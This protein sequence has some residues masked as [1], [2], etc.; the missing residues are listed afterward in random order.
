MNIDKLDRPQLEEI[1]LNPPD[2]EPEALRCSDAFATGLLPPAAGARSTKVRHVLAAAHELLVR[3][4][5]QAMAGRC[6]LDSPTT[7][8]D[9]VKVLLAGAERESFVVIFLDAQ[10]R[11]LAAEEMF[12]GTLAQTS[13]YPREIVRRALHHNAAAILCAHPH[14]SGLAE[15]SRADEFLTT[16]LKV[17]LNLVDVRLVDHLVVAGST[18]VSFAERG[19]L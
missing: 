13:V 10:H 16:S 15:P 7:A 4:A 8:K 5:T 18:C 2:V 14:P 12:A 9:F 11:V 6:L 3:I 1:L 19:L 17:A